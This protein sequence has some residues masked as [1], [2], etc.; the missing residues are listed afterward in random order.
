MDNG[1]TIQGTN[2]ELYVREFKIENWFKTVY[3]VTDPVQNPPIWIYTECSKN[4]ERRRDD[5][6]YLLELYLQVGEGGYRQFLIGLF[7]GEE[8]MTKEDLDKEL[9]EWVEYRINDDIFPSEVSDYLT[10]GRLFE[11]YLEHL[12]E[13]ENHDS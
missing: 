8:E 6:Y 12:H 2:K 1:F 11:Q 3:G 10:T 7:F 4:T 5:D 9:Y 13:D